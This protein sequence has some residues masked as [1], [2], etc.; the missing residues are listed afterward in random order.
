M[1]NRHIDDV[2]KEALE[3]HEISPPF[4]NW[5]EIQQHLPQPKPFY[6]QSTFKAGLA[7]LFVLVAGF[8]T[9]SIQKHWTNPAEKGI[10]TGQINNDRTGFSSELNKS[11]N[12]NT[13]PTLDNASNQ[14]TDHS[15]S[16]FN[17]SN[18]NS[19]SENT[20]TLT[21]LSTK[22]TSTAKHGIQAKE[23]VK[24]TIR[25]F[26][27]SKKAS[28]SGADTDISNGKI[29]NANSLTNINTGKGI[30]NIPDDVKSS[31]I[32]SS[33][34]PVLVTQLEGENVEY[35]PKSDVPQISEPNNAKHNVINAVGLIGKPKK[36]RT[37]GLYFGSFY[38][39]H[40]SRL[41]NN[42]ALNATKNV[43]DL[44]YRMHS[45]HSY[46]FVSG[47]DFS[48]SWGV[49][50][51]WTVKSLEGQN[52]KYKPLES[53]TYRETQINLTYTN[54]P[55][56]VKYRFTRTAR[57]TKQPTTLNLLAGVQYGV[58]KSAEINLNNP[59]IHSNLLKKSTWG[60]IGGL[61]YDV[62]LSR[63]YFLSF[64]ARAGF[65]TSSNS[66]THVELPDKNSANHLLLGLRASFNYRFVH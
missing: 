11:S 25:N 49:Q 32:A 35:L 30:T 17:N 36:N 58:L 56:L 9:F 57:L 37:N 22:S 15:N 27:Q 1:S 10:S 54:V 40:V 20:T 60:I 53:V 47:Y 61:D 64:G 24:K 52:I 23:T 13:L 8:S 26:N 59:T 63:N 7:A 28:I 4:R 19:L 55:V 21:P 66:F 65:A 6:L 44:Q 45:G 46:G 50:T 5:D 14:S 39:V 29:S 33:S 18:T 3:N 16:I 48:S 31:N 42:Q 2:F 41:L 38:G 12:S 51:E 43:E 62:Y 34:E